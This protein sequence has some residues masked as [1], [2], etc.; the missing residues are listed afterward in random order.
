[1]SITLSYRTFVTREFGASAT[2]NF[3]NYHGIS[4]TKFRY[5]ESESGTTKPREI[6]S[7]DITDK[8]DLY[9][10]AGVCQGETEIYNVWL[11]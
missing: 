5:G 8:N 3:L 1:M 9:I 2:K 11:E 4:E 7:I 6:L 10:F